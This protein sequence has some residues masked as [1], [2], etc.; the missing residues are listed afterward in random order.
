MYSIELLGFDL[1]KTFNSGQYLRWRK[2][3]E[4]KYLVLNG[5][6][7][8]LVEQKNNRLIL[9]CTEEDFYSIWVEYFDLFCDYPKELSKIR[10]LNDDVKKIINK[11]FGVHQIHQSHFEALI[12]ERL[13]DMFGSKE[14]MKYKDE[15]AKAYGERKNQT[16]ITTGK[17]KWYVFPTPNDIINGKPKR[18]NLSPE[19]LNM[20]VEESTKLFRDG[21]GYNDLMGRQAKL[22]SGNKNIFVKNID[23]LRL[24]KAEI[25]KKETFRKLLRKTEYKSALYLCMNYYVLNPPNEEE[26]KLWG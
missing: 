8:V 3:K 23:V 26:I 24:A 18:N 9:S 25:G 6:K 16:K 10:A 12:T 5:S 20:L 1:D 4:N 2:I 15:I 14:V 22:L 19:I 7:S 11:G 17:F 21:C 13:I